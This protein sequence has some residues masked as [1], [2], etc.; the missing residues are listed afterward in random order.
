MR[1]PMTMPLESYLQGI[2]DCL[3]RMGQ[4]MRLKHPRQEVFVEDAP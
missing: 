2:E 4:D 1:P 3:V